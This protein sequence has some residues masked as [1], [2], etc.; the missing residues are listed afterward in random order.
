M[1]QANTHTLTATRCR[2]LFCL[3]TLYVV[4]HLETPVSV[5]EGKQSTWRTPTQAGGHA[6][7]CST[8]CWLVLGSISADSASRSCVINGNGEV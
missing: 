3:N 7:S 6:D 8:V 1:V 2:S 5:A 4:D